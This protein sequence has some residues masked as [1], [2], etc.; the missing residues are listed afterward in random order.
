[1]SES[2]LFSFEFSAPKTE[3]AAE[4]LKTVHGK[5]AELSPHFFSVAAGA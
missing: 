2:R 5:L 1:M 4:K 3:E